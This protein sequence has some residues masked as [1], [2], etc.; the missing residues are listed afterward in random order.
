MFIQ[1]F[2]TNDFISPKEWIKKTLTAQ[3]RPRGLFILRGTNEKLNSAMFKRKLT[4]ILKRTDNQAADLSNM[5]WSSQSYTLKDIVDT[6]KLPLVVK[7]SDTTCT[8][9]HGDFQFDLGESILLHSRKWTRKIKVSCL[10]RD[11]ASGQ[12]TEIQPHYII[13]EEYEGNY[14]FFKFCNCL[15]TTT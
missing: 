9:N 3:R 4:N 11:A 8:V 7:C 10:Q 14:R 15:F 2:R 5:Q 12:I 6:F 1:A 13:P